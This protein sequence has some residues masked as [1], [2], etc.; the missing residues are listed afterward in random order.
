[1]GGSLTTAGA[2][3]DVA[4]VSLREG[5]ARVPLPPRG[6]YLWHSHRSLGR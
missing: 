1:M 4:L 5:A 3:F 2:S 6:P